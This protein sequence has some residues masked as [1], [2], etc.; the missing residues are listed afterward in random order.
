M[1]V[2][3][4]LLLAGANGGWARDSP[5]DLDTGWEYRWGDSPIGADGVPL[6]T[7]PGVGDDAWQPIDFPSNPPDRDG[8]RNVWYRAPLPEGDWRDP[9]IYI[10]SV[11]LITEV[12]LDGHKI[13]DFGEFDDKGEGVFVG[14]PWHMIELPKNF[15]DKTIYFRI[16]SNYMDI[17]L[18]GEIKLMERLDL[19]KYVLGTSQSRFVITAL[20]FLI[21]VM[22]LMLA[23]L[24]R[25]RSPYLPISVFTIATGT[26]G[27]AGTQGT[28]LLVNAPLMWDYIDAAAYYVLPAAM[29]FLFRDWCGP[30][31]ARTLTWIGLL[32][33]LYAAGAMSCSLLGLVTLSDTYPVF[34]GLL[35]IS[36]ILMF[37]A[38]F[39]HFRDADP[40]RRAVLVA[41]AV[42]SLFLMVDMAVAH[43]L[44]PWTTLPM[45]WGLFIF[46]LMLIVLAVRHFV[47]TQDALRDLNATLEQKVQD[48]TRDLERSN[49]DLRQ[50]ASVVS[51][52]LQEP[53]RMISG[54]MGLIERRY[55]DRLDDD[56]RTFIYHAVDGA[57]RMSGMIQGVLEYSRVQSQGGELRGVNADALLREALDDLNVASAFPEAAIDIVDL[58]TLRADAVQLRSLFQNLISNALK[59]SHPDRTP[60]IAVRATVADGWATLSI[61]DNGIGIAPTQHERA[62]RMF[63]RL[64]DGGGRDGTGIGLAICKRIVERHGGRI[65]IDSKPGQGS[66][67]SFTLP[68]GKNPS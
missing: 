43:S 33:A 56:G 48:R 47:R 20:S 40:K 57:K 50:F 45:P 15:G 34:D 27:L 36:L 23:V 53:L 55:A 61:T 31:W 41:F 17:G 25:E 30:R 21:A 1:G 14:W 32:H 39:T 63:A 11:D 42:F 24:S 28:Q 38:T 54:Y 8:R 5:R 66:T 18:W 65:W 10:Y 35:T 60:R 3:I 19:I 9:V 12:Y 44:L 22:A 64:Q 4:L 52:D 51:H 46:S 49:A 59:Y 37:R 62:F 2:V 29:A 67:F 7:R 6:W 16:F 13:Y 26:M 58:P 68:V